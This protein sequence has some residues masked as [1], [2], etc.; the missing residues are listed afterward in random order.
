ADGAEPA[1]P[2]TPPQAPPAAE[3]W[4]PAG[5]QP[6][7][8][9]D[10]YERLA[11]AGYEYGPAFRALRA[12]WR[13]GTDL[14][15]EVALPAGLQAAAGAFG[16]HPAL[17]DAVLHAVIGLLPAAEGGPVRLPFSWAG[18]TL[19]RAGRDMLRVRISPAGPDTV[20]LT[21]TDAD[22]RPVAAVRALTFRPVPAGRTG[23]GRDGRG[24]VGYRVRWTH[25]PAPAPAAVAGP[26]RWAI[27]GGPAVITDA[28]TIQRYPDVARLAA[29][30]E[31][32]E[33]V[34]AVIG[35][36]DDAGGT[37]ARRPL[38]ESAGQLTSAALGLLQEWLARDW[39]RPPHLVVLTRQAVAARDDDALDG[40]AAAGVWGLIRGAQ[41]EHPGRVSVIDLDGPAVSAGVLAAA[42]ASGEPQL[43]VR[44][45]QLLAPR[46]R[47]E[48]PGPR[49]DS[50][51]AR[52][53][54]PLDPD[55]TVLITG[56]TGA[57]GSRTARRLVTRHG[58]R[59]LLLAGRAGPAAPGAAELVAELTGLGAEVT[60][61]ACDIAD[62][63]QLAALLGSVP[64]GHPLTAVIHAAGVLRD[65]S[66]P[67][68]TAEQ[69]RET[70]RPKVD[71][72]WNLHVLTSDLSLQAFVLFSSVVGLVGN[73]GQAGYAAASTFLDALAQYRQHG[74]LPAT[75][76]AWGLWGEAGGMADG[77]TGT[78]LARLAGSGITTL[79]TRAA[80]AH[81]DRVL[82]GP[83]DALLIPARLEAARLRPDPGTAILRELADSA[84]RPPAPSPADAPPGPPV[85]ATGTAHAA[86]GAEHAAAGTAD[87]AAG[88]ADPAADAPAESLAGQ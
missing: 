47:P 13:D 56:G 33:R 71:A 37:A 58:A 50:R 73:P 67:A 46:I 69:L 28:G 25:V 30:A 70:L 66:L 9:G 32:P 61:A 34:F 64:A 45:G 60:V 5:A 20:A 27:L 62:R 52:A 57:L 6:A 21:A 4:P 48:L 82:A 87:R 10:L 49:P 18:V 88:T 17:L 23:T 29:A 22:G 83:A 65:A 77:L 86:A 42:V 11:E 12:A 19:H 3:P 74:G 44:D 81:L 78:W 79:P 39:P 31:P 63:D 1:A 8:I 41:V 38:P 59:R 16:L 51:P 36:A 24:E 35:P 75:S 40:L 55:G 7:D 2:P 84:S 14:L 43:A 68:L 26:G 85:P 80:L 54:G 76:L 72:A 53:G 15:A